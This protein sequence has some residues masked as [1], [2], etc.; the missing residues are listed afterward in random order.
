MMLSDIRQDLVSIFTLITIGLK[1]KFQKKY[2]RLLNFCSDDANIHADKG[3]IL[4]GSSQ[5]ENLGLYINIF[6]S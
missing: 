4:W 6:C 3:V 2:L 1:M 5:K